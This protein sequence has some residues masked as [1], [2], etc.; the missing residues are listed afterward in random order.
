MIGVIRTKLPQCLPLHAMAAIQSAGTLRVRMRDR[1]NHR[2]HRQQPPA[3]GGAP[4]GISNC[5]IVSRQFCCR[6]GSSLS[7]SPAALFPT[8][9]S[10]LLLLLYELLLTLVRTPLSSSLVAG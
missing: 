9:L 6:Q 2:C 4:V 8:L 7:P 1:T 10:W 5:L 3:S